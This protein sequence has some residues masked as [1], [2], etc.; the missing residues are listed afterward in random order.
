LTDRLT[1]LQPAL[2]VQRFGAGRPRKANPVPESHQ[3]EGRYAG[4]TDTM[5]DVAVELFHNPGD[6]R[7]QNLL[8]ELS[9]G[10]IGFYINRAYYVVTNP[11]GGHVPRGFNTH[12]LREF[13]SDIMV[14]RYGKAVKSFDPARRA[15]FHSWLGTQLAFGVKDAQKLSIRSANHKGTPVA[16]LNDQEYESDS[17]KAVEKGALLTSDKEHP[18]RDTDTADYMD[19]LLRVMNPRQKAIASLRSGNFGL[20]T[21]WTP[22]QIADVITFEKP[23]PPTEGDPLP[24][25]DAG[26]ELVETIERQVLAKLAL[27]AKPG[28]DSWRKELRDAIIAHRDDLTL[29]EQAI[30]GLRHKVST[31]DWRLHEIGEALGIS[32]SG[33]SITLK[34]THRSVRDFLDNRPELSPSKA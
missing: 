25:A 28:T 22:A 29:R 7:R 5:N 3:S 8:A 27:K 6:T 21:Q 23:A 16:S 32:E 11:L 2:V 17:G 1:P 4:L 30:I 18:T 10:L 9:Q 13:I 19:R 24:V 14:D 33:V 15:R 34:Q 20:A 31:G 26:P 12:S